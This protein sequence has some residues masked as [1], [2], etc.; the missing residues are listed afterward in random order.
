MKDDAKA[1]CRESRKIIIPCDEAKYNEVREDRTAFRRLPDD[2]CD[3]YPEIFPM[4]TDEGYALY[5]SQP[6]S[7]KLGVRLRRIRISATGE[8]YSI[9]PSFVLPYMTA[10]T[11]DAEKGL[12]LTGFGVPSWALTYVFGRNDMFWYRLGI[13]FGRNSIVGTTVKDAARLPDR[14][15]SDE[16]HTRIRGKKAYIATTAGENCIL[17]ASVC[18]S[19]GTGE[20]AD[21]YH[22]FAEE[23]LD[24]YPEYAPKTVSTD[25]WEAA[26]K[27]WLKLFPGIQ[28]ILCFL[29]AFLSGRKFGA[30]PAVIGDKVRN[31]YAAGTKKIFSQRIRRFREWGEKNLEGS[32]LSK[33]LRLCSRRDSFSRTYEHPEAHRTSNMI[34]RLMRWQDEYLFS[35]QYFHGN[36]ESAE[37]AIRSWA[38]IRNFRPYCNRVSGDYKISAAVQLNGFSYRDNWLENLLVSSSMRGCRK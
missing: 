5:G 28:I 24:V 17:G 19:A 21:A 10:R 33:V 22:K 25:G 8:V 2:L 29:H 18:L 14:L 4:R 37:L 23:A 31:I 26:G 3:V 34:D 6:T 9:H 35:R 30:L 38:L 7:V 32:V 20:L 16:K 15:S 12:F 1:G 36:L 27:A 13:S 11:A